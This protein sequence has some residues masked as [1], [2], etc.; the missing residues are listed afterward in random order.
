MATIEL[1]STPL[2]SNA[3][4]VSYYRLEANSNDSKSSN[5]GTD[6]GTVTY[7]ATYGKFSN[8]CNYSATGYTHFGSAS[9]LDF[10]ATDHT[11]TAWV[12]TPASYATDK[13]ILIRR[14]SIG[15][16]AGT[17]S[18][19]FFIESSTGKFC[20]YDGTN[21]LKSSSGLTAGTQYLIA[22]VFTKATGNMLLYVNDQR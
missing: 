3:N 5:N 17:I 20:S 18:A 10:G 4:L 2:Y 8:G 13:G 1:Y 21:V 22:G 6:V 12:K 15:G 19:G 7:N 16:G 14:S 11:F 9:R